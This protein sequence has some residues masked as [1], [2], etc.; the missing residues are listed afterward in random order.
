M[1]SMIYIQHPVTGGA[2]L[3]EDFDISKFPLI[4]ILIVL[5]VVGVSYY[6]ETQDIE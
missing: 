6:L 3:V 5:M 1:A 2:I 4:D